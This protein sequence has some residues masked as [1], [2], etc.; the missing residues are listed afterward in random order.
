MIRLAQYTKE[1]DRLAALELDEEADREFRNALRWTPNDPTALDLLRQL[2]E[3][4]K[5]PK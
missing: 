4:T 1:L 5:Q 2:Q 3:T